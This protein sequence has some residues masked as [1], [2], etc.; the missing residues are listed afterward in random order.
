MTILDVYNYAK[1]VYSE[2]VSV[3]RELGE[4]IQ[5]AYDNLLAKVNNVWDAAYKLVQATIKDILNFVNSKLDILRWWVDGWIA[6][7]QG[8][9]W[10]VKG[11]VLEFVNTLVAYTRKLLEA[12]IK[13]VETSIKGWVSSL[14]DFLN[15]RLSAISQIAAAWNNDFAGL[16]KY[17]GYL[18]ARFNIKTIDRLWSLSENFLDQLILFIQNPSV[19]IFALLRVYLL[20]ML[21]WL[22]ADALRGDKDTVPAWPFTKAR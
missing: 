8:L 7:L 10:K 1:W 15:T 4:R 17:L 13:L 16:G 9:I 3:Y 2:L 5:K 20:P 14:F 18:A 11:E 6:K 21:E 22:L 19:T 12:T